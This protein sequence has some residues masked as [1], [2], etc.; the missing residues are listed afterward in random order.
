MTPTTKSTVAN[1]FPKT[2]GVVLFDQ[3]E[4]LDFTG[5]IEVLWSARTPG[6][7]GKWISA[8]RIVLLAEKS[9]P[10][11]TAQGVEVIATT[12]LG[13]S[14][15]LDIFMI[16][17]GWGTRA[18]MKNAMLLDWVRAKHRTAELTTSVCTGALV[19]GAAGLLDGRRATTHWQSLDALRQGFPAVNVVGDEQVVKDGQIWTAAGVSAG[20]DLA[21]RVVAHYLGDAAAVGIAKA[22]EYRYSGV[23]ERVINT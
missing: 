19:L 23:N 11:T 5:P 4:L 13:A 22:I 9:G 17:G 21:L 3:V 18:Q 14:P 8:F 20:I 6:V 2:V 7:N 12:S 10:I 1:I 16:P 15:P